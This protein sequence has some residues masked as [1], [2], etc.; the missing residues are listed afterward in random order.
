MVA[1]DVITRPEVL[2]KHDWSASLGNVT[3]L[4]ELR[5]QNLRLNEQHEQ[6]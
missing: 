6:V 3:E 5:D 1:D 2:R 4:N